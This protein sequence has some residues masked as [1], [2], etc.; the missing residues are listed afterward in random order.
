MQRE[1]MV[2]HLK[3]SQD[4]APDH[5][6]ILE[7]PSAPQPPRKK[8][9]PPYLLVALSLITI[10]AVIG[11]I[12]WFTRPSAFKQGTEEISAAEI[13]SLVD[14][15]GELMLLPTDEKPTVATVSDL[16]PLKDQLFFKNAH[17]GDMVFMYPKARR[18]IL[19]SPS[20][21]KIIEVAP[22]TLDTQ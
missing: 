18:A 1:S 17:V 5:G 3:N 19:Y 16:N 2:I 13:T 11:G 7:R 12:F 8:R 14:K 20:Q 4:E 10:A 9:K 15:V 6:R 22:I 21:N